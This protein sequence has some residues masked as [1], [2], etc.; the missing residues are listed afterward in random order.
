LRQRR[1]HSFSRHQRATMSTAKMTAISAMMNVV[2]VNKVNLK[3][4]N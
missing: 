2:D 1:F 4:L 3:S